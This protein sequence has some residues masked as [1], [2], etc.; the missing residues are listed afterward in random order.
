MKTKNIFSKVTGLVIALTLVFSTSAQASVNVITSKKDSIEIALKE[1]IVKNYGQI[2]EDPR[3]DNGLNSYIHKKL[4]GEVIEVKENI[5]DAYYSVAFD[6][7]G[8][9][10]TVLEIFQERF[11]KLKA[12]GY[13][14][15]PDR[16]LITIREEGGKTYVA[17]ALDETYVYRQVASNK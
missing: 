2:T 6:Q 15:T 4:T 3:L 12:D 14:I 5:A 13:P 8:N 11:D 7:N 9:L 10:N 1:L 16:F 17:L